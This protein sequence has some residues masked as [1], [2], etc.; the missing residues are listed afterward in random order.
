M[1]RAYLLLLLVCVQAAT[2]QNK[3]KVTAQTK[4]K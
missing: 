4:T 2:L 1:N 3:L